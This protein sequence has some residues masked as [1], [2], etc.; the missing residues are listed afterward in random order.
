MRPVQFHA[1]SLIDLLRRQRVA[2]MPELLAALG[3][4]SRRTVV[5]KLRKV[6]HITSYSHS[7]GFYALR[8]AARFDEHGLWSFRGIRFSSRG[9]L[10]AT[11]EHFVCEAPSGFLVDELDAILGSAT[12]DALSKLARTER[13]TRVKLRNRY[14]Y[15][16]PEAPC[17][18]R[19]T[20]AKQASAPS[21]ETVAVAAPAKPEL[22]EA[23]ERYLSTLDE[24]QQR[25]FAGLTSLEQGRGGDTRVAAQLGIH[26]A[27]VARGRRELL[28]GDVLRGRSR[29]P[30]GGLKPL[31]K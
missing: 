23:R 27:T 26:P 12:T 13:L 22:D 15:L 14:L 3:T 9:S 5:R 4:A 19:Q 28:A 29:R 10:L 17:A 18:R 24:Q 2:S 11:A 8:A 7:G 30:D 25:L 21:P 16:S 31:G 6:P 1:Q 20:L